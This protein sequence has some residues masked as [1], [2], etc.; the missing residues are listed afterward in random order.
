MFVTFQFAGSC[1]QVGLIH[2]IPGQVLLTGQGTEPKREKSSALLGTK[3]STLVAWSVLHGILVHRKLWR[4]RPLSNP[5]M[6]P[7]LLPTHLSTE[8]APA[9]PRSDIHEMAWTA[10]PQQPSLGPG[11]NG[12]YPGIGSNKALASL[13]CQ[14]TDRSSLRH[15]VSFPVLG[16][17]ILCHS[18]GHANGHVVTERYRHHHHHHH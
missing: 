12:A 4:R 18:L 6:L 5:S 16:S 13:G 1:S 14:L 7:V 11:S 3:L 10:T 2:F 17:G 9:T 8:P 15:P